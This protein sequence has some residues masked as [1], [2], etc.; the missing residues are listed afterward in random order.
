[1]V[2][3]LSLLNWIL[4]HGRQGDPREGAQLP[5][6]PSAKRSS[7]QLLVHGQWRDAE[8]VDFG[9]PIKIVLRGELGCFVVE[10]Q[11]FDAYWRFEGTSV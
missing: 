9:P 4:Q 6:Q 5:Q 7:G 10:Q 1:M 2:E 3:F 8:I 11:E